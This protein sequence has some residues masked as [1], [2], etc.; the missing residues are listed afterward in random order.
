M[1]YT[2]TFYLGIL[3][4]ILLFLMERIAFFKDEEF[5]RAVRDTMGKDRMSLAKRREKPIRGIIWERSLRKMNFLSINFKDY[6][7]KDITDL[8]HFKNV[9]TIILTYMGDNEEEKILENWHFVKN[10]KNLRRVQLYHLKIN[11]DVKAACS[12]AR[13]FID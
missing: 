2:I 7:V 9:E 13:V 12:N 5:L 1:D 6:H 4:I 10:F 3:I 8:R 11:S